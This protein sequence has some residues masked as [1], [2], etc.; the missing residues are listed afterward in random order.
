MTMD[1][2][3]FMA[4]VAALFVAP[5]SLLAG[6]GR[7]MHAAVMHDVSFVQSPLDIEAYMIERYGKAMREALDDAMIHGTGE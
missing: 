5:K 2:R 7:V 4:G 6:R 3:G 1:R